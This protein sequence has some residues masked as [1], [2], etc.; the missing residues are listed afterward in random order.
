MEVSQSKI[1]TWRACRQAYHYK[2]VEKLTKK[3]KPMPFMRGEIIHN[4]L[5]AHY[6][7]NDPW[8]FF[9]KSLKEHEKALRLNPEEYGDLPGNLKILMEAYFEFYKKEKLKVISVEEEFRTKLVGNI[10]IVGKKDLVA[11]EKGLNWLMEHKCH[12]KIPD[13]SMIPYANLQSA[14]YVWE[15]NTNN[16]TQLDG[17]MWNYLWGKPP[18]MP[19]I[20]KSG[21][22]TRRSSQ[23]TWPMYKNA[24][25]QNKLNPNDYLD[26]KDE[27]AGNESLYFQRK[28]IPL[29]KNLIKNIVEDAKVTAQEIQKL[30][31]KD[32]TRNLGYN[33]E[34]CEFKNL[35]MAQLKGLD[36]NFIIKSDFKR[37]DDK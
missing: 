15:H 27:L 3:F 2:Y 25:K 30:A 37:R 31:G 32:K 1:K 16:K 20:L 5:E 34:K 22:M 18:S 12:N 7:G 17:I 19:K 33:C 9:K 36:T 26:V 29:N 23:L 6:L 13:G 35:C 14:I 28:P 11:Q 4:M 21:E 10:Y 24:L 8:K